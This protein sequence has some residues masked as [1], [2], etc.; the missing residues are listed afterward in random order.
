LKFNHWLVFNRFN[1][2]FGERLNLMRC[3]SCLGHNVQYA[4]II[5]ICTTKALLDIS[6]ASENYMSWF[7]SY[8]VHFRNWTHAS[9]VHVN[10]NLNGASCKTMNNVL[11]STFMNEIIWI[12]MICK[13]HEFQVIWK[14][15]FCDF[16]WSRYDLDAYIIIIGSNQYSQCIMRL[17]TT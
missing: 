8:H 2:E 12:W 9:N 15:I 17:N 13:L 16:T 4:S 1:L 6:F 5:V 11:S 14:Y 3:L 7:I 10:I